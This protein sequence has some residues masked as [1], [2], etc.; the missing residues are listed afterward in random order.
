MR[1]LPNDRQH[2]CTLKQVVSFDPPDSGPASLIGEYVDVLPLPSPSDEETAASVTVRFKPDASM[3]LESCMLH[4]HILAHE[5]LGMM[6]ALRVAYKESTDAGADDGVS[7]DGPEGAKPMATASR[8][9]E[10]GWLLDNSTGSYRSVECGSGLFCLS[11]NVPETCIDGSCPSRC[12]SHGGDDA[13]PAVTTSADADG[14]S[15]VRQ[16]ATVVGVLGIAVGY[17]PTL[18]PPWAHLL[19]TVQTI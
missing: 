19:V 1:V 14:L 10:C 18:S 5:D 15:T 17:Y 11:V 9:Q 6:V 12:A 2:Y 3:M 16:V 4:C 8:G 13:A 7:N